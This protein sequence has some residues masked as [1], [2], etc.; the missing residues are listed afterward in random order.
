[1]RSLPESTRGQKANP[2]SIVINHVKDKLKL[3]QKPKA[4]KIFKA[5]E[6]KFKAAAFHE[7]CDGQ[8][9][10]IVIVV[11]TDKKIYGGFT[12]CSWKKDCSYEY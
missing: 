6:H 12:P 2:I 5:S 11:S 8:T 4:K 1:M 7:A 10:T 3:R 9:N